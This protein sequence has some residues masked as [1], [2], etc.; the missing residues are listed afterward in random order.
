MTKR[1][2][3]GM[4]AEQITN[5]CYA[6]TQN[7]LSYLEDLCKPMP[8]W[9]DD[10]RLKSPVLCWVS[11]EPIPEM[12]DTLP[13]RVCAA[14]INRVDQDGYT[15]TDGLNWKYARPIDPDDCWKPPAKQGE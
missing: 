5:G 8:N 10:V 1:I 12:G 14:Y 3:D 11:D 7:L 6:G 13:D 2:I 4:T 15:A 9:E